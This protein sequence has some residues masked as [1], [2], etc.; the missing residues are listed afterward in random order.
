[1]RVGASG[2]AS[3]RI[4][5][6]SLDGERLSIR[7]YQAFMA[8][9]RAV[10]STISPIRIEGS[11]VGRSITIRSSASFG[12]DSG[13]LDDILPT[14]QLGADALGQNLRLPAARLPSE[15]GPGGAQVGLCKR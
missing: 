3:G 14:W 1:M 13:S 2:A 10:A 15:G 4:G 6:C 8:S 11:S 5:V 7:P 9:Y 12:T